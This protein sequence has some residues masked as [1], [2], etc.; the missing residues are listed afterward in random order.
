MGKVESRAFGGELFL[1]GVER[2]T[3]MPRR[4]WLT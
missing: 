2:L 3:L 1:F 4:V